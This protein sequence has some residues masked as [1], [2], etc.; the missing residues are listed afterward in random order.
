MK[1][2]PNLRKQTGT[3]SGE[4]KLGAL[5]RQ[6]SSAPTIWTVGLNETSNKRTI[7]DLNGVMVGHCDG[8]SIVQLAIAI[9]MT[10]HPICSCRQYDAIELDD[11]G[12]WRI[13]CPWKRATMKRLGENTAHSH[14]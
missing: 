5:N 4:D 1:N 13:D 8:A 9:S 3:D 11:P 10:R 2:D 6:T 12:I 7:H 14:S